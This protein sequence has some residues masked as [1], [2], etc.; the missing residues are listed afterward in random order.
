M[1]DHVVRENLVV[2]AFCLLIYELFVSLFFVLDILIKSIDIVTYIN[3]RGVYIVPLDGYCDILCG[4]CV[5]YFLW[6]IAWKF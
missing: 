3:L 1:C 2:N 4:K 6:K 5:Q